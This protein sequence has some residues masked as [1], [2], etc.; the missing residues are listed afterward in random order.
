MSAKS[1]SVHEL[2]GMS[3]QLQGTL[4]TLAREKDLLATSL[5]E[6]AGYTRQLEQEKVR[7]GGR[8]GGRDH[9]LH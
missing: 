1:E 4:Q 8:E 5:K 3:E 2:L 6:E 7:D 9:Q